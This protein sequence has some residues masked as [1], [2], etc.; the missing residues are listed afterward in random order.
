[1]TIQFYSE[2]AWHRAGKRMTKN[3]S[4]D[5]LNRLTE[6]TGPVAIIKEDDIYFCDAEGNVAH[7]EPPGLTRHLAAHNGHRSGSNSQTFRGYCREQGSGRNLASSWTQNSQSFVHTSDLTHKLQ[8]YLYSPALHD[9]IFF[10]IF[11]F[12]SKN[13]HTIITHI[14]VYYQSTPYLA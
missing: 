11:L 9:G 10:L 3:R 13:Q 8:K 12:L 4:W 6:Q 1:M 7:I 2:T 14:C 5:L